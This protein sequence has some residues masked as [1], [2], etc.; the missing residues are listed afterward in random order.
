MKTFKLNSY[1]KKA[2]SSIMIPFA[3]VILIAIV[4]LLPW[5]IRNDYG[6]VAVIVIIVILVIAVTIIQIGRASCRERV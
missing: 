5:I 1:N 2:F 4:P 6:I 3:V